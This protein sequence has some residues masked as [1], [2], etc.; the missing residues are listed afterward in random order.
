MKSDG[1][2]DLNKFRSLRFRV[3]AAF[4]LVS[5]IP[6]GIAGVFSVQTADRLIVST[7]TN[8]LENLAADKAEL[9][10]RWM[11]ERK[12]DVAVIAH[13]SVVRSFD[14]QQIAPYLR[15]MESQYRVYNRFVVTGPGGRV[16]YDTAGASD[17]PSGEEAYYREARALGSHVS[18]VSW[19]EARQEAVFRIAE[20]IRNADELPVGMV[21]ATVS[22]QAIIAQVLRLSLGETGE[23]YLVDRTGTFLAHKQPERILKENIAQSESFTNLFG[24]AR[25]GPIYTD[26]R[27]I[28]VLGASRPVADT[29]WYIVVEQDRD[30]AFAGSYRMARNIQIAIGLTV[31][32]A[33]GLSWLL[34]SSVTSPIRSLS[35][36]ADALSRGEFEQALA[37]SAVRRKDEIGTLDAAFRHM[38]GQLWDRHTRLQRQIG[39][40]EGQLRRSEDKLQK[41]LEAAAR[42]ERLA[43]LG[44]LA[45]GV[46]HEMRTPLTSLKLFLQSLCEDLELPPDQAEDF[47]VG[48]R[49]IQRME[50]TIN[51]F[52]DFARPKEPCLADIDFTKLVDDAVLVVEPRANQ[53]EVEVVKSIAS[54]LPGVRGDMRQ[55]GEV[56]VNLLVN[57]L[58]VMPEGGRLSIRVFAVP[59]ED[60]AGSRPRA[61]I[62]VADT[63]P[64]VKEADVER[65]FE[66]FFTTKASG[67]G[68]GLAIARQTVE[69][70]GGTIAV[71]TQL[72]A[73]TTFSVF[74]P[75]ENA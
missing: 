23:C 13:C 75:A 41:T 42:S 40:A 7:V 66:P 12:A 16:L 32:C 24:G 15:L 65:L 31:L 2:R 5:T 11:A 48:M 8:Q 71:R 25:A 68:L 17:R 46:A 27:G 28:P 29:P 72:G 74:L 20:A 26:Y 56:V 53:Q 33:I 39:T 54:A 51:H 67:S 21:C 37:A 35:E 38:A 9:L 14:P 59:G 52:L 70:H 4:L 36:A 64:G 61:C 58:E 30:E 45:A 19:D 63:G 6:L 18:E 10:R 60:P 3:A 55:L 50:T 22:T 44:R 34:A 47:D 73:G 62:E 69:R 1:R 49:Q 43:A 57:A